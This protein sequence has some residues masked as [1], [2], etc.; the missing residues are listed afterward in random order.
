MQKNKERIEIKN[1]GSN[2]AI[3][4]DAFSSNNTV[5]FLCLEGNF[6]DDDV[7]KL[8]S[9]LKNNSSLQELSLRGNQIGDDGAKHLAD[10]L[11]ENKTLKRML[12][13]NNKIG[14][15]GIELIAEALN[16]TNI[17]EDL[18]LSENLIDD[19]GIDKLA[20]ALKRNVTLLTLD[21]ANNAGMSNKSV[22]AL[23]DAL[24]ENV[25][26]IKVSMSGKQIDDKLIREISMKRGELCFQLREA[27]ESDN[28]EKVS[29]LLVDGVSLLHHFDERE[30][31][32]LHCAL[33]FK[34]EEIA[35]LIII[36]MQQLKQPLWKKN[37]S[38]ETADDL[39]KAFGMKKILEK[40]LP[41]L[42]PSVLSSANNKGNIKTVAPTSKTLEIKFVSAPSLSENLHDLQRQYPIYPLQLLR[43]RQ[44][45]EGGFGVVYKGIYKNLKVAIKVSKVRSEPD[46]EVRNKEEKLFQNEVK[47][48]AKFHSPYIVILIGFNINPEDCYLVMEYME[49]GSLSS[50]LLDPDEKLPWSQRIKIAFHAIYGLDYLHKQGILYKD[51]KSDNILVDRKYNA[52]LC[53]LSPLEKVDPVL[54]KCFGLYEYSPEY[55]AWEIGD[56]TM[57]GYTPE[58]DI[59]SYG[60]ILWTLAARALPFDDV[61][62]Q[63][64]PQIPLRVA[65]GLRE[66]IPA[67]CPPG[68]SKLIRWCWEEYTK[69]PKSKDVIDYLDK[70]SGLST[71]Q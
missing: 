39:A 12:L 23:L 25:T 2:W 27:I 21:V 3:F 71:L 44:V 55:L 49:K 50:V 5:K 11:K 8:V 1:I 31:T 30:E 19:Q 18:D 42:N 64:H 51:L 56:G 24:E 20:T 34:R 37:Q 35:K 52:K 46:E 33:R 41:S 22:V 69:R 61:P 60:M 26:I 32:P 62:K 7:G 36:R 65:R 14:N 10:L 54:N 9:I 43:G 53:D 66:T 57:L 6:N 4:F 40:L 47:M 45:G 70:D 67:D 16:A 38:G 17:L 15:K 13:G 28:K 48:M 68:I 59:Y 29:H 63:E 58:A